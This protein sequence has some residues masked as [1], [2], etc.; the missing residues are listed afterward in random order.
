MKYKY[1]IGSLQ[2]YKI[3]RNKLNIEERFPNKY[4]NNLVLTVHKRE[5][6]K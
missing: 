2:R 6:V 4:R 5:I 1:Y 3:I